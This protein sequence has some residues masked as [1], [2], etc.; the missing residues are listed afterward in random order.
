MKIRFT[1]IVFGFGMMSVAFNMQYDN[2]V[3]K[4]YE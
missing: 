1:G 3:D 2:V 4:V